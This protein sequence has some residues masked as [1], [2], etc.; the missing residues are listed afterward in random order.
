VQRHLAPL[1]LLQHLLMRISSHFVQ[2][3]VQR[4]QHM[5]CAQLLPAANQAACSWR[6]SSSILNLFRVCC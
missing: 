5:T 3:G 6:L 2:P 4:P 1:Q